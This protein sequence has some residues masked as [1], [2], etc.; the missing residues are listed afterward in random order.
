MVDDSMGALKPA[1]EAGM[2]TV[3]VYDGFSRDNESAMR[4]LA[5]RYIYNLKELL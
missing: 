2:T 5:D 4:A 3:G 1:K